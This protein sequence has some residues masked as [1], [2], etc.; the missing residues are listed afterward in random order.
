MKGIPFTTRINFELGA[1]FRDLA[2][3][4]DSVDEVLS[5]VDRVIESRYFNTNKVILGPTEMLRWLWWE[6]TRRSF[7]FLAN[8]MTVAPF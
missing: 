3:T 6:K 8:E 4:N 2:E 7:K 1:E 5:E